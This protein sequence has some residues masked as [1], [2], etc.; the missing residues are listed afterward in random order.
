METSH[1]DAYILIRTQALDSTL[2]KLLFSRDNES[3]EKKRWGRCRKQQICVINNHVFATCSGGRFPNGFNLDWRRLWL[4]QFLSPLKHA[5]T[6]APLKTLQGAGASILTPIRR[7][8]HYYPKVSSAVF[9]PGF[10]LQSLRW[11]MIQQ[12]EH[13][14]SSA[15]KLSSTL[16]ELGADAFLF[17]APCPV[18]L[19]YANEAVNGVCIFADPIFNS[20]CSLT[21]RYLVLMIS[22]N[23]MTGFQNIVLGTRQII[24]MCHH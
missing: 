21:T 18:S 4:D 13:L 7:Q 20:P 2:L 19:Q 3:L 9:Y 11:C 12:E 23:A 8:Q 16:C 5:E 22:L 10:Y 15:L 6:Q 1:P 24:W 17:I 14:P